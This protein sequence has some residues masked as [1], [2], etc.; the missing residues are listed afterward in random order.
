[1]AHDLAREIEMETDPSV[2]QSV[3]LEY[4]SV[5]PDQNTAISDP[6][7]EWAPQ[8]H[9]VEAEQLAAE[10][11]RRTDDETIPVTPHSKDSII[12]ILDSAPTAVTA[13]EVKSNN[14]DEGPTAEDEA[15][16]FEEPEKAPEGEAV[17]MDP[18]E[19]PA[20]VQKAVYLEHIQV[21][22]TE[23]AE[24]EVEDAAMDPEPVQ[25]NVVVEDAPLDGDQPVPEGGNMLT[26]VVELAP[27]SAVSTEYTIEN[28]PV[29][30]LI[31]T[32][33]TTTVEEGSA[34]TGSTVQPDPAPQPESEAAPEGETEIAVIATMTTTTITVTE[35]DPIE[36]PA[37]GVDVGAD[38]DG[39]ET[40]HRIREEQV[41]LEQTGEDVMEQGA[42][43]KDIAETGD[44]ASVAM[45]DTS[46]E[47]VD[48]TAPKDSEPTIA[49]QPEQEQQATAGP[50]DPAVLPDPAPNEANGSMSPQIPQYAV[51]LDAPSVVAP[52]GLFDQPAVRFTNLSEPWA[53]VDVT[54]HR[55]SHGEVL[56]R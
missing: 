28:D 23:E 7:V 3:E 50:I 45:G 39:E 27:I 33:T 6:E 52:P 54:Y 19:E 4:P 20:R 5:E 9:A 31:E 46:A 32:T 29:L 16:P 13:E 30:A 10:P 43:E 40:V 55:R 25:V 49:E 34:P 22:E 51:V 44:Q 37:S 42:Q 11:L 12:G 2:G 21:I 56:V 48:E 38:A 41:R 24:K 17:A 53:I 8:A 47:P 36:Q 14:A 26:P 1:M 18:P 35:P 15:M